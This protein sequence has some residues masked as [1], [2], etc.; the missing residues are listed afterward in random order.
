MY[1][2]VFLTVFYLIILAH[3]HA[4]SGIYSMQICMFTV[5]KFGYLLGVA[6]KK[7]STQNAIILDTETT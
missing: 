7:L 5:C 2:S 3:E 1:I 4:N 6:M